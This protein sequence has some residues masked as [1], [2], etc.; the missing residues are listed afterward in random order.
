MNQFDVQFG[1]FLSTAVD[2][3]VALEHL[4]RSISAI[5]RSGRGVTYYYIGKGSGSNATQAIYRRYKNKKTD[6]ELTED[7]ALFESTSEHLVSEL[8]STLN[9]HYMRN[10]PNRCLNTGGGSAGRPSSQPNHYIYLAL[11]RH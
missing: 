5:C 8:E 4:K 2:Y 3:D 1:E 9:D 11:R 10:D 7:W 6:W